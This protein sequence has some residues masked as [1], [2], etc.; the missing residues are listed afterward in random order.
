M[1]G[2]G[3]LRLEV[4]LAAIDKATRPIRSVM[5]SSKGLSKQL[6]DTRDQLKAVN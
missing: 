3:K 5:G 6:R 4:V 2:T 1:S